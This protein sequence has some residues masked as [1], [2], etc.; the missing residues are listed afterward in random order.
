MVT[1]NY[2]VVGHDKGGGQVIKDAGDHLDQTGDKAERFKKRAQVAFAASTAAIVAFGA[3]SLNAAVEAETSQAKLNDAFERFPKLADVNIEALRDLNTEMGKKTK[4][5]D[6]SLASGQ[7]ILANFDLTGKQILGLTPLLADYA[8]KTGQDVPGAAEKLGKSFMGNTKALKE[9]GINYKSTGDKAKDVVNITNLLREKVGGFAE[10]EGKTS[11]GQV[12]ILK[13]Q[14]GELQE[15]IGAKLIPILMK[16]AEFGL[17]ALKWI[18]ENKQA[19]TI[20][21]AIVAA[22]WLLNFALAAN[23]VVLIAVGIAALVAGLVILWSKSAAFRDFFID[24]WHGIQT[25]FQ[26]YFDIYKRGFEIIV[27]VFHMFVDIFVAGWNRASTVFHM[28]IDNIVGHFTGTIQWITDRWND[29][30]GFFGSVARRIGEALSGVGRVIG[31]AFKGAFNVGIDA[32]NFFINRANDAIYGINVVNPFSDV[33]YLPHIA[34]LHSGGI[35]PGRPGAERLSILQ[36]GETV[37]PVGF[38]NRPQSGAV[39][40]TFVGNT[41][42]A[43]GTA[44]MKLVRDGTIQLGTT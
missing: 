4:F 34:R 28:I 2:D 35:V 10:K 41:D 19:A 42:G 11:A 44:F 36:A 37:L 9:L 39:Q 14:F 32:I 15:A 17:G 23:P 20:I 3:S 21:G 8:A 27:D 25:A 7:A 16:V 6:D 22:L 43:F 13:N 31:D 38:G 33:P 40:V 29:F 26:M 30:I 1:I 5:D 24:M 18:D 12:A